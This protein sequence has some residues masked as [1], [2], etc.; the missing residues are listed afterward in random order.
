MSACLLGKVLSACLL[1]N[2][3]VLLTRFGSARP[4]P[5]CLGCILPASPE[6]GQSVRKLRGAPG[7]LHTFNAI[8]VNLVSFLSLDSAAASYLREALVVPCTSYTLQTT[9]A[10]GYTHREE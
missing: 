5:V 9:Q 2:C 1:G 10:T 4:T 3:S 7:G 8:V 6:T